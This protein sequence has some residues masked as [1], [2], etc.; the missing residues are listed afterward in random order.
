MDTQRTGDPALT[1]RPRSCQAEEADDVRTVGVEV[2]S[3][4][5]PVQPDARIGSDNPLV[6]H[7]AEQ[8]RV[9]VLPDGTTELET[10]PD[11]GQLGLFGRQLVDREAPEEHEPPSLC[12]VRQ[13]GVHPELEFGEIELAALE[14]GRRPAGRR[15]PPC[16]SHDRRPLCFGQ[17]PRP[18]TRVRHVACPPDCGRVDWSPRRGNHG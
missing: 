17:L 5:R 1:S 3:L 16:G 6:S 11:V 2:L 18:L 10:Q 12:Q 14:G 13:P 15:G 8:G 9:G 7:V 4:P